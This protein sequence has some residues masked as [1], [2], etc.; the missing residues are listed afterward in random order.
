MRTGGAGLVHDSGS[1]APSHSTAQRGPSLWIGAR[2]CSMT[3]GRPNGITIPWKAATSRTVLANIAGSVDVNDAASRGR[4]R[5]RGQPADYLGDLVGRR[6][7]AERD[8]GDDL[9]P[10][11]ALQVFG[12]HFGDREARGHAEA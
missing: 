6:D 1:F 12:G 11:A 9:R 10:A 5:L 2:G 7:A 4:R 3:R 8:V